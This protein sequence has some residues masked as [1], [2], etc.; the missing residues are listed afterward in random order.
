MWQHLSGMKIKD[1][2]VDSLMQKSMLLTQIMK[3]NNFFSNFINCTTYEAVIIISSL[4][5]SEPSLSIA[6]VQRRSFTHYHNRNWTEFNEVDQTLDSVN[7]TSSGCRLAS[8]DSNGLASCCGW[9]RR[10]HRAP[11]N[12]LLSSWSSSSLSLSSSRSFSSPSHFTV[13]SSN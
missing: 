9:N 2:L 11:T 4:S 7:G 6:H 12:L 1:W 13:Q 8:G 5:F 10:R 3:L